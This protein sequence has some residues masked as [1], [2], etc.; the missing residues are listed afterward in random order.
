MF[1]VPDKEKQSQG[2]GGQTQARASPLR[3][4]SPA[5]QRWEIFDRGTAAENGGEYHHLCYP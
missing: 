3:G 2:Q 4:H 5:S 1:K